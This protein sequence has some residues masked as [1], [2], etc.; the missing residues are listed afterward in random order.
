MRIY[1]LQNEPLAGLGAIE[2]WI[3]KKGYLVTTTQVYKDNHFLSQ[4]DYDLLIILGGSMGAYEKEKYPWLQ[5]EKDYISEAIRKK[6]HVLGICLGA[7]LIASALGSP[8][9]PHTVKE[10]G[11][12][13]LKRTKKGEFMQLF[14]SFP[15]TFSVFEFHGDTYDLPQG[16]VHLAESNACLNQAFIYE[17]RVIG[18]QFH[19][20]FTENMINQLVET[21]GHE[22][23]DGRSIQKPEEFVDRSNLV[24]GAHALLFTLLENIDKN[25]Q[26][27]LRENDTKNGRE[28]KY[29]IKT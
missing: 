17:N 27:E 10:F 1:C 7:Q 11:W 19:P 28:G 3:S 18:L 26:Q 29:D 13:Q 23:T 5:L 21:F 14:D 12:C 6:K 20:E 8:V 2:N 15:E 25:Y 4:D 9:Y 22:W 16:A 24:E